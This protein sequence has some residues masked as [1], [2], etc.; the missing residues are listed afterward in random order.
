MALP[1]SGCQSA[2]RQP[3]THVWHNGWLTLKSSCD[4][5]ENWVL[6][7]EGEIYDRCVGR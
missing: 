3:L 5:F 4:E 2:L 6:C 1:T 7:K